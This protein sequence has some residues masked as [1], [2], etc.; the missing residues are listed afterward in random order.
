MRPLGRSGLAL[1]VLGFGGTALGKWDRAAD[2][3]AAVAT[4]PA[5]WER[6]LRYYDTSPWYGR[7]L[8]EHRVGTFL[9]RQP[10]DQYVLSTKV[11]RLLSPLPRGATLPADSLP[12]SAR[13]DYSYDA[14]LRSVEDSLQ[15]LGLAQLDMLILH[16]LSPRWQGDAL[17]A[18]FAIA[19]DG[20]QRALCDLRSA[21]T[22]KAIG[23]GVNDVA[24]CQRCLEAGDFDFFMLAGRMTLLD[25]RGALPLLDACLQRDVAVLAAAP[26]NSG[27]LA[28]GAT[29]AA[30]YFYEAASPDVM[31]R[32]RAMQAVCGEHGVPLGAAALQFALGHAAVTSVVPSFASERELDEICDWLAWPIAPAFWKT[33]FDAGHLAWYPGVSA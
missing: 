4:L 8:S 1:S 10:R 29:D 11:G 9:R 16:D 33:L 2:E 19:M 20:A 6:G 26:F 13:F 27:I 3:A 24:V 32:T 28:T 7:G 5:A 15:R 21:G 14:T 23:V 30:R 17:D 18:Q 25:H 22:V 31:A 12:F